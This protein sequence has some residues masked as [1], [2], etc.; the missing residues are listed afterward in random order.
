MQR[1][2]TDAWVRALIPPAQGRLEV[3]DSK[4][5]GL[6]LRLTSQGA[7]SWS[8]RARTRDGKQTRVNLGIWPAMGVA[9][10]RRQAVL[11]RAD[12]WRGAD[13]VGERRAARQARISAAK[14][15]PPLSARLAE[16]QAVKIATWS[17]R[18]Q[19]E[20]A[21]VL[22]AEIPA[23]M[24]ARP[25]AGLTR[26][27][28]T[29][30]ISTVHSRSAAVGALLYRTCSAFL[31]HAEAYGWIAVHPL[32]RKG[33]AIIAPPVKARQRVLA[34]AEVAAVWQAAAALPPKQRAFVWLLAA[35]ACRESEAAD[36][37]A[38]EIDTAAAMWRLPGTRTKNGHPHV[39][40]LPADVLDALRAVQSDHEIPPSYR[41]LGAIKGSGLRGFSKLKV[42]LDALSGVRGWR[43][44]DLRRTART[45]MTRLGVAKDA[46]EIALNHISHRSA[47][48]RTYDLADRS[49]EGVA[50]LR[51]WQNY[52]MGLAK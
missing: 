16:W 14:A 42:R 28:W 1:D 11:V 20:V 13:P 2:I 49:G 3:R 17:P 27:D 45:G 46:A 52:L 7:A 30:C 34:D 47:L 44:H 22:Q 23:K 36:I 51:T 41:L 38:G 33:A 4:C 6:V 9:A 19:R 48:E 15:A 35:T 39:M 24:A 8:T 18:Y 29:K 25:L 5:V 40:P 50:A 12:I 37:A 10:A 32:P 31:S 21:R 43:F 26:E